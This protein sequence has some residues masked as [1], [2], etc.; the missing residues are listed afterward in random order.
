[1]ELRAAQGFERAAIV[2]CGL[3]PLAGLVYFGWSA[4]MVIYMLWLDAYLASLR[5][6][7]A[8]LYLIDKHLQRDPMDP[9]NPVIDRIC[10]LGLATVMWMFLALPVTIAY[11]YLDNLVSQFHRGGLKAEA[12]DLIFDAPWWFALLAGSRSFQCAREFVVARAT[13]PSRFAEALKAQYG[14]LLCKGVAL[15]ALALW[16][17]AFSLAGPRGL[18]VFVG[19]AVVGLTAAEWYAEHWLKPKPRAAKRLEVIHSFDGRSEKQ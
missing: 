4:A 12:Y 15:F 10:G 9:L 17:P 14:L 6:I 7:P 18:E 19:M 11:P 13:G 16:A 1:M 2:I 5:M 8:N 3:V